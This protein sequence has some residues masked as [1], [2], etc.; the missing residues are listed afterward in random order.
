M[1]VVMLCLVISREVL[2]F[3]SLIADNIASNVVGLPLGSA[4][5]LAGVSP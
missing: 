5:T 2:G 3:G 1:G 4:V